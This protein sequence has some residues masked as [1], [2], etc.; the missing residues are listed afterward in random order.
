MRPRFYDSLSLVAWP[1][2]LSYVQVVLTTMGRDV[3]VMHSLLDDARIAAARKLDSTNTTL[4]IYTC[5]GAEWKQFG[6]ARQKRPLSSVRAL[7]TGLVLQIAPNLSP[8]GDSRRTN[9][10]ELHMP[11]GDPR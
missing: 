4:T 5:W 9:R 10:S 3:S 6:H 7:I 8:F 2:T 11:A 1:V